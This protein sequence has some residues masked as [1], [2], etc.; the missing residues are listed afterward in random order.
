MGKASGKS[1]ENFKDIRGENIRGTHGEH[2]HNYMAKYGKWA[3][4]PMK[5]T[6]KIHI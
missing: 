3:I 6:G 2:I 1:K 5:V 4:K